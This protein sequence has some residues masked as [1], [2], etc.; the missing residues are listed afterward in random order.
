MEK[1]KFVKVEAIEPKENSK[2]IWYFSPSSVEQIKQHWQ[3]YP[4]SVIRDGSRKIA[5]RI[6]N[7]GKLGT[8]HASNEFEDAVMRIHPF[9]ENFLISDMVQIENIAY[10]QRINDFE[11]GRDIYLPKNMSVV[12]IDSR[13]F[14]IT[15]EVYKDELTFPDE[16]KPCLEDVR[17]IQWD[18]GEHWYAKVGKLDVTD[19]YNH[20]KWNTKEQAQEAAQWFINNNW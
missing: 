1:Y 6:F 13:F 5:N 11:R 3:K 16:D 2:S 9:T 19:K 7:D 8:S 18:G 15:E 20:Q 17:Y 10:N 12:T 14:H 4:A